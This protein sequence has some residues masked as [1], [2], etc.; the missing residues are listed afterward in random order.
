MPEINTGVMEESSLAGLTWKALDSLRSFLRECMSCVVCINL[1]ILLRV[2][3]VLCCIIVVVL[4]LLF[5]SSLEVLLRIEES[6]AF[7]EGKSWVKA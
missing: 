5:Y 6:W 3:S 4:M 1:S 7:L 2:E